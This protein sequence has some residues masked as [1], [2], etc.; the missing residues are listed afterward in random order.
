MTNILIKVIQIN[1]VRRMSW[2]NKK[3]QLK[4]SKKDFGVSL[5]INNDRIKI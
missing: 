1:H 3:R 4:A 2:Y 5:K